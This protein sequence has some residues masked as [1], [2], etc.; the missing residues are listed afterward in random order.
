[1]KKSGH[2]SRAIPHLVRKLTNG[3][4]VRK[5]LGSEN[6]MFVRLREFHAMFQLPIFN[7]GHK[8]NPK[9]RKKEVNF[10]KLRIFRYDD[11]DDSPKSCHRAASVSQIQITRTTRTT[12][13]PTTLL[14]P[15]KA[16]PT[17]PCITAKP[18]RTRFQASEPVRFVA[19][20]SRQKQTRRATR[21]SR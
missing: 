7:C 9:C 15:S 8:K 19:S 10:R 21:G 14:S 5:Q 18:A 2:Y 13:Q 16:T 11:L 20:T 4:S 3:R 12:P 6:C 17:P 1:M